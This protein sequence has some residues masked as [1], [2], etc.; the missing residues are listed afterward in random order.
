MYTSRYYYDEK[1]EEHRPGPEGH[2]E[3]PE[4]I[5]AIHKH[6]QATGLLKRC[7]HMPTQMASAKELGIVH[8]CSQMALYRHRRRHV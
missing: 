7:T 8:R 5:A 3:R 6:L 1:M 4:R 2:V